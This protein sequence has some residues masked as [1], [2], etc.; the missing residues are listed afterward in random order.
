[1]DSHQINPKHLIFY[2]LIILS[3]KKYTIQHCIHFPSIFAAGSLE[4]R[5]GEAS[6]NLAV[7]SDSAHIHKNTYREKSI[8][9]SLICLYDVTNAL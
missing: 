3:A 1:M 9:H 2:I 8:L 6:T 7:A 5:T 4:H